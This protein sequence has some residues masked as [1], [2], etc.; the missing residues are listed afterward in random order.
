MSEIQSEAIVGEDGELL[1]ADQDVDM[2]VYL[3]YVEAA[4]PNHHR[5]HSL[6]DYIH[7]S[8]I[9]FILIFVAIAILA[10]LSGQIRSQTSSPTPAYPQPTHVQQRTVPTLIPPLDQRPLHIL[11]KERPPIPIPM[12]TRP[13]R[14]ANDTWA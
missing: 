7:D 10:L 9:L 3:D 14:D 6:W 12:P 11:P 4:F 8:I 5:P 1:E 2:D 13:P